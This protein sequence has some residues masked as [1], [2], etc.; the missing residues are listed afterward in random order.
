MPTTNQL[1][2]HTDRARVGG[3]GF[4]VFTWANSPILY[5][6]QISHQSP[7]PVGPGPVPIHPM[8]TPYPVE[9]ITPQAAGVGNITLELYEHFGSQVWE[10]L[11]GLGKSS[12]DG[13][14]DIVG[15]YKAVANTDKPI[16]VFKYIKP[17]KIRGRQMKPY[18]EEYHNVIVAA[19]ED[20]ETIEVGT[21]EV[22]KQLQLQYTHMTRGG[23][24]NALS[25]LTIG[26]DSSTTPPT[27]YR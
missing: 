12:G 14:V 21:M 17:P 10:R 26:N 23:R 8:D 5:A 15:I 2:G 22:L 25:N 27:N 24:N 11:S 7:Q 1:S 19:I 9:I 4:T 3:S 6:R 18:T 20:G 16:R 13:P